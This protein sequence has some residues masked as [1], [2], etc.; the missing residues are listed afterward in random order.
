MNSLFIKNKLFCSFTSK[1]AFTN[2]ILK[3]FSTFD[4]P[5]GIQKVVYHGQ[6]SKRKQVNKRKRREKLMN[7]SDPSLS[8]E[9]PLASWSEK[10][11]KVLYK[12]T[13][14]YV[15]INRF[16]R[17]PI[18]KKDKQEYIEK[19][20][21]MNLYFLDQFRRANHDKNQLNESIKGV[22]RTTQLLPIYLVNEAET[23]KAMYPEEHPYYNEEYDFLKK[24][25]EFSTE[26]LYM[27]QK[28]RLLPDEGRSLE[29][30]Y[31]NSFFSNDIIGIKDTP[32]DANILKEEEMLTN[33][34]GIAKTK[35]ELQAEADKKQLLKDLEDSLNDNPGAADEIKN[36]HRN[37]NWKKKL[38]RDY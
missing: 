17:K 10:K 34:I 28:L 31:H 7:Q 20:K 37:D 32:K 6:E 23:G 11:G 3:N 12:F 25:L 22:K 21:E 27:E 36:I 4:R 24:N 8:G 1:S 35:K 29:R 18:P 26:F 9:K 33:R 2:N 16:Y 13:N 5:T 14:D 15:N 38:I 30:V 19:S